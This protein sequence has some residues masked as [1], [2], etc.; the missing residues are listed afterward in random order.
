[1]RFTDHILLAGQIAA[2][3]SAIA[4]LIYGI[5]VYAVVKPIKAY[6]DH[7]TYQIQPNS[8]GGNSLPDAIK[9]IKKVDSKIEKLS[10]RLDIVET[11]LTE[12]N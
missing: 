9:A 10:K 7:A 1:M 4:A 5:V 6:I 2:A 8:N 3:L 12:F 11:H